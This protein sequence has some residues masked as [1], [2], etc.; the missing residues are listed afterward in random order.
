MRAPGFKTP[1]VGGYPG[2]RFHRRIIS[3]SAEERF[4]LIPAVATTMRAAHGNCASDQM[5][6]H[7]R[8]T[9]QI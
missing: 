6:D 9:M 1:V 8:S 2:H 3:N 4:G 7:A 5:M